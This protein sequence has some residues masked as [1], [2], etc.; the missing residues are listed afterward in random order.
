[1]EGSHG[2]ESDGK[3]QP[4]VPDNDMQS[5]LKREERFTT[6]SSITVLTL[7]TIPEG[8]ANGESKRNEQ[9]SCQRPEACSRCNSVSLSRFSRRLEAR[10]VHRVFYECKKERKA[11]S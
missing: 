11:M 3:A 2:Q 1:M 7:A 10:E 8:Q 4:Y 9:A 6:G 5:S